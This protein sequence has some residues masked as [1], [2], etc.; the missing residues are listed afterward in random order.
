[1]ADL[2][3]SPLNKVAGMLGAKSG[4]QLGEENKTAAAKKAAAAKAI[5]EKSDR[6]TA[7]VFQQRAQLQDDVMKELRRQSGGK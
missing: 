4:K 3:D 7:T 5:A 2:F 1:M 6:S